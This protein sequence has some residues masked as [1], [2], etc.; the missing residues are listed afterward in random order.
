VA[1]AEVEVVEVEVEADVVAVEASED[2]RVYPGW[3]ATRTAR[4]G[5]RRRGTELPGV[6]AA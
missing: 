1:V 6:R 2:V 4:A 5:R 3:A